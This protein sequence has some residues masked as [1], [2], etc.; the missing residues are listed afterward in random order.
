M[1]GGI[2]YLNDVLKGLTGTILTNEGDVNAEP[3]YYLK[4]FIC[5]IT[6]DLMVEPVVTAD[7]N[8]YERWAIETWFEDNNTSPKTNL[9]LEDKTLRPNISLLN[10]I[11]SFE[12]LMD[13]LKK[14]QK[15]K[16][17][18]PKFTRSRTVPNVT[19]QF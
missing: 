16:S 17:G 13:E 11:E 1:K 15:F 18:L 5:P 10:A 7:G 3:K 9:S 8:T 12:I 19:F 2:K 6:G 4:D 14:T